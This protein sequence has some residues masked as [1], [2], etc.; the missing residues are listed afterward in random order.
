M[1]S[2]RNDYSEGCA[3]QIMEALQAT[4]M[5]QTVG[6]GEGDP[7]CERARELIRDA[8][9]QPDAMVEFCSGGTSANLIAVSGML[10][11]YEGVICTPDAHINT[12]ETG[13]IGACARTILPTGD[14]NGFLSPE[15]CE[16]VWRTQT[17]CGR[18]M[19]RPGLIY[20]T[21]ATELGGVWDRAS[22]DA[23]CDW[24][25]DHGL[26]IY[27]DGARMANALE[28]RGCDLSLAHIASRVDALTLGG[29]KNGLLFG[30]AM[31]IM[32]DR[33]KVDFPYLQKMRG[34]VMA[35][36]RLLGVQFEAA[37]ADGLYWRM[38]RHANEMADA[39][40]EG[41]EDLGFASWGATG[42]NQRF[43]AMD[44]AT[45]ATFERECGCERWCETDEG[46]QVIRFV[47]S[48]ATTAESIDEVVALAASLGAR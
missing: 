19:T 40:G 20:L 2:F 29:T 27:V 4:N 18:H 48:W 39:L 7:Y 32:D 36:G 5:V 10:R 30:E 22:F 37:L 34:G 43:F 25:R 44:E 9:G 15:G 33:L 17:S 42:T 46:L 6:Y 3:P 24:A 38:A 28:A 12:H 14:T 8:C 26:R 13:A 35:K 45:A 23:I 21:N 1:R 16:R 41:L 11:D 31:V 47:C